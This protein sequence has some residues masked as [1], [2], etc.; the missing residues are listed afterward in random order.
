MN[1]KITNSLNILALGL[2]TVFLILAVFFFHQQQEPF[3]FIDSDQV[4]AKYEPLLLAND[5]VRVR[6]Q[7]IENKM[8]VYEDSL[9]RLMDSLS[10]RRG[11]EEELLNL[12]NLES[13][14]QRHKLVDSTS[15]YAQNELKTSID[16]FN[17][18]AAKYCKKNKLHLLFST[19]NNTIVFGTGSKADVSNSF[20]KFMEGKNAK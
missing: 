19:S 13:N 5:A 1:M 6:D 17:K 7:E 11:E 20:I 14:I 3:A 15:I 10:V 18:M 8:K 4:L 2:S 16:M 12:L 9:A